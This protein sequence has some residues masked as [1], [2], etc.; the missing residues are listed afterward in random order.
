MKKLLILLAWL[1]AW[2]MPFESI[3]QKKIWTLNDCISKALEQN[4]R[5]RQLKLSEKN[6]SVAVLQNKMQMLPNISAS[7]A[8]NYNY[9][10]N[11]DPFTNQFLNQ[12]VQSNSIQMQG[13]WNL[14][15]G[16]Q[17]Q[18]TLKQNQSELAAWAQ[19]LK[20][21]TNDLALL[22]AN[23]YLQ[24]LLAMEIRETMRA[25]L[26]ITGSQ[27]NRAKVLY[28]NGKASEG[29][30][31]QQQAQFE[32]D[33]YNL[34]NAD[35]QIRMAYVNLWLT[36][37]EQPD[38]NNIIAIP[39]N[40]LPD[41]TY[42]PQ[43]ETVFQTAVSGRPEIKSAEFRVK[44]AQY[45]I[46]AASG[47]RLPRL[48]MF[49]NLS[50]LYSSSRKDITGFQ[51]VGVDPIGFVSGSF[52][53]VYSPKFKYETKTT[54]LRKQLDD[55]YGKSFGLSLSIPISNGGSIHAAVQ[56]NKINL[57]Q[58]KLNLE[59]NRQNLYK[60]IIQACIDLENAQKKYEAAK[61]NLE[62]QNKNYSFAKIRYENGGMSFTDYTIQLGAKTRAEATYI[63]S[64]Y[65]LVFREKA[66]AFYEGKT[67]SF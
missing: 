65:E 22:I 44:A 67:I 60:S 31:V 33:V 59:L 21:N 28:E 56:R 39:Q 55:N 25:Q 51:W 48:T 50:T 27:L 46:L 54:A 8:L 2:W 17:I 1:L 43:P 24:V 18:N 57:E 53:T 4:I 41:L 49:G 11:I 32:N 40:L 62:A 19:D 58:Q 35:N 42:R 20:S 30:F 37:N 61:K 23:Q 6:Q 16:L 64:R 15:S 5:L 3:A 29:D 36:M 13:T 34:V 38:T 14:F 47:A 10:R 52:D 66:V 7:T 63:Q 26:N 45:G 9:G 12:V